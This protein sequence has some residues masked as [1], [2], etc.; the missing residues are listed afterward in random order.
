MTGRLA[1]LHARLA[2]LERAR[3]A[4]V[5]LAM[6]AALLSSLL[7]GL[8]AV[9]LLD[10]LF[11][12]DILQRLLVMLLAAGGVAYLVRKSWRTADRWGRGPF[13]AA[14]WVERQHQI[15]SDLI[16]AL[17]FERES[18]D[19]SS[20]PRLAAAV[21]DYVAAAT[22]AIDV[23][24]GFSVRPLPGR[25]AILAL[26]LAVAAGLVMWLPEHAQVFAHRLLLDSQ[27]YPTRTQ[28]ARIV[29][30]DS[31]AYERNPPAKSLAAV[32]AA[33]AQPLSFEVACTGVP[34]PSLTV[35]VRSAVGSRVSTRV[36]LRPAAAASGMPAPYRGELPRVHEDLEYWIVAGDA[37]SPV[38]SVRMIALPTVEL[39]L[40]AIPPEYAA[41]RPAPVVTTGS[42][43]QLLEGSAV[44]FAVTCTNGKRLERVILNL[45]DSTGP[46]QCELVASDERQTH[47]RLP[48][49][50]TG[51]AALRS[52][53]QYE[54][55]ATDSDGLS[56]LVPLRG[57][58][59]VLPDAPP[60]VTA[61]VVH[62]L[63]LPTAQPVI[64][65][66]LAD[67]YGISRLQW[68]LAIERPSSPA[69][70]NPASPPGEKASSPPGEQGSS[71]PPPTTAERQIDIEL[72]AP[73]VPATQLPL[74]GR[75][76]VDLRSLELA[77]GD[78]LKLTLVAND[79]RGPGNPT[80]TATSE[81]ILLEVADESAVL[82]A[83]KQADARSEAQ[84]DE[85]IRRQL[86]VGQGP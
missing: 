17:Q 14:L 4:V 49:G 51:L 18:R 84:L 70:E 62:R 78:R 23:F 80:A 21:V 79:Y 58:L 2:R 74:T 76:A 29:V 5:V 47:W 33:E 24:Q 82:G 48:P 28:I 60:T 43:S 19:V 86:G 46:R 26:C 53:L 32:T 40:R 7:L 41:A 64:H 20:S 12:L 37:Q 42:S 45:H 75:Y 35:H 39:S 71:A 13:P 61:S 57:V 85:I 66:Q 55:Q 9:F 72:P 22:P 50:E 59:R 73:V 68:V 44:E 65:Y 16:A 10:W 34:P 31:V 11:G 1:L 83:I 27:A 69:G 54:V 3:L 30:G 38:G 25:L 63:I 81:A 36:V 56:P 77:A 52:D 67:D 15:D 8:L 6:M